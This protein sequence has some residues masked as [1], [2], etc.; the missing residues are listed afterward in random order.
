MAQDQ[1][2]AAGDEDRAH[3]VQEKILRALS[4][5]I[6]LRPGAYGVAPLHFFIWT[7]RCMSLTVPESALSCSAPDWATLSPPSRRDEAIARRN[8]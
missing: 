5:R 6:S 8:Y 1:G 3:L 4:Q 2:S 7:S